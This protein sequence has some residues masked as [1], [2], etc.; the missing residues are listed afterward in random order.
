MEKIPIIDEGKLKI[1]GLDCFC[2]TNTM[3]VLR[4]QLLVIGR[5]FDF[6]EK[7]QIKCEGAEKV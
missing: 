4:D 6:E 5:T 2:P 7:C 3:R 1:D